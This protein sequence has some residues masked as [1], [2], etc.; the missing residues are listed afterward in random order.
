MTIVRLPK[1]E[2]KLPFQPVSPAEDVREAKD[3]AACGGG[4]SGGH[5]VLEVESIE[6]WQT[7]RIYM[8][9]LDSIKVSLKR[10]IPGNIP[11]GM[12]WYFL[13]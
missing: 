4:C 1:L 6:T 10:Q 7:I 8:E 9:T 2:T 12:V 11:K 13:W 5:V 3:E